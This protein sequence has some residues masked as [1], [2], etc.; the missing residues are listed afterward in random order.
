MFGIG[1]GKG[2]VE[3]EKEEGGVDIYAKGIDHH[4]SDCNTEK[5]GLLRPYCV[6]QLHCPR[7]L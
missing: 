1:E 7:S 5:K 6:Q 2:E 3:D 4:C